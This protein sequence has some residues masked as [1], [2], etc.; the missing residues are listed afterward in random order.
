MSN[1][2]CYWRKIGGKNRSLVFTNIKMLVCYEL[3]PQICVGRM[4]VLVIIFF[5]YYENFCQMQFLCYQHLSLTA[6]LWSISVSSKRKQIF[7]L[8]I[9]NCQAVV[10]SK[11]LH[12]KQSSLDSSREAFITWGL[13]PL[14]PCL[15]VVISFMSATRMSILYTRMVLIFFP[16]I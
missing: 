8:K 1:K 16:T 11:T 12:L 7:L 6:G 2:L 5:F 14:Y 9:R 15:I 4:D 3:R 10:W 13:Y